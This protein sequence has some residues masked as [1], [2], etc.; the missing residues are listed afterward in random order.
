ML[1]APSEDQWGK[2]GITMLELVSMARNTSNLI[3]RKSLPPFYPDC[4]FPIVFI[5][6]TDFDNLNKVS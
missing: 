4:Y 1:T 2:L 3:S 6:V 5:T